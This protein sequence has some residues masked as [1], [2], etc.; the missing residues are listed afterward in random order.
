[1]IWN[2][3]DPLSDAAGRL[4]EEELY[5][6]VLKEIEGGIRRDGVWAKALTDAGFD[7]RSAKAL[8]MKYRI[9]SLK[10]EMLLRAEAEKEKAILKATKHERLVK[11]AIELAG[12]NFRRMEFEI[13]FNKTDFSHKEAEK[14]YLLFLQ[15]A[16]ENEGIDY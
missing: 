3:N 6:M 9:Q 4:A 11:K 10:D 16:I 12:G 1:M 15:K 13:W 14:Q 5:A 8:Y 7:E 2:K